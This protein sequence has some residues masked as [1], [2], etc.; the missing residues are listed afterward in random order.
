[1]HEEGLS[2]VTLAKRLGV[3]EGAVRRLLNPDHASRLDGV[4]AALA[5]IG[6]DLIIEDRKQAV[7]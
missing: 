4:V 6:R 7:A 2:N 3:T 5:A 1:M